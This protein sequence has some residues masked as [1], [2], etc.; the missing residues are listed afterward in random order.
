MYLTCIANIQGKFIGISA[1][2]AMQSFAVIHEILN[3]V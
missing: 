2:R 3:R 1:Q